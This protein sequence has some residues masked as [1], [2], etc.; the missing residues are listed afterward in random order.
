L[1]KFERD[2]VAAEKKGDTLGA[3]LAKVIQGIKSDEW[4][5]RPFL[6]WV[7]FSDFQ[8]DLPLLGGA[9]LPPILLYATGIVLF[10]VG[11][12]F[13]WALRPLHG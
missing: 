7:D 3:A 10:W 2:R 12:L 9:F 1:E 8:V 11:K 4:R 13:G 5:D 6:Y